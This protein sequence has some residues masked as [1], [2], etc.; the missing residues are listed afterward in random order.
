MIQATEKRYFIEQGKRQVSMVNILNYSKM[1]SSSRLIILIG[2]VTKMSV[3]DER[4]QELGES[5]NET[6]FKICNVHPTQF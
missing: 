3:R 4:L 5:W 6:R 1:S 2:C